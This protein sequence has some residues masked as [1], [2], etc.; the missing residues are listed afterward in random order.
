MDEGDVVVC[1]HVVVH[2]HP[3]AKVIHLCIF[4]DQERLVVVVEVRHDYGVLI[5]VT[6]KEPSVAHVPEPLPR[7]LGVS[8]LLVEM[9]HHILVNV[10]RRHIVLSCRSFR[11]PEYNVAEEEVHEGLLQF[12]LLNRSTVPTLRVQI[13][14]YMSP[15]NIREETDKLAHVAQ[16]YVPVSAR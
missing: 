10:S 3:G 16:V 4:N 2:I 15:P 6:A 13:H 11:Q 9:R 7:F 14:D 12:H 8:Q 5:L 1:P